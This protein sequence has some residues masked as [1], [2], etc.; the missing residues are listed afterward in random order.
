MS[1]TLTTDMDVIESCEY[2]NQLTYDHPLRRCSK[3]VQSKCSFS[4]TL[5]TVLL[6][7]FL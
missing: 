5:I 4:S 1:T 7:F 6:C 2:T 3:V